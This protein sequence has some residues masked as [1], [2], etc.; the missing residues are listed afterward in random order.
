MTSLSQQNLINLA[1]KSA[2]AGD[3]EQAIQYLEEALRSGRTTELVTNL[4]DLYLK[5]GQE[6]AAFALIKEEPDLFSDQAIFA[7]YSKVLQAN[8]FLIEAL[9]VQNLSKNRVKITVAPIA[10]AQ[11]QEVMQNFKQ[12]KQVTQFD[13]EQLF[14]LDLP[15]FVN[16]A[17]S[18]L[19]DPSL[20]FAVR[21]ALCED[22]VRLGVKDKIRVLVLGQTE[23][24]IPQETE[25]LEKGTVYHEIISAIGS[26][27]YHR[28]NQ[29]PTVLGEVN[30]I[31]GSLYPKLAK[32]VDEPDSF[33]S[34]LA[35]YIEHHDGRGHHKLFEQI[36]A[37][38]P[39]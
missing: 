1:Q 31:L 24:F 22:L 3:F 29:L 27:Y 36:Y 38:L 4:C 25:L 17:Q 21:I 10:L 13:Y 39:K 20:N 6:Y 19:L 37:N 32:Y 2:A 30:L 9:E 35:S 33:A 5:D 14:K 23:E 12:K 34:D 16:F 11:Q 28:P 26:R 18:L 7:E 15:N 8:H